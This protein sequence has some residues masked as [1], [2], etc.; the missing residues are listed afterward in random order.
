MNRNSLIEY[1]KL[2]HL[3]I[4]MTE[5]QFYSILKQPALRSLN[6]YHSTV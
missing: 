3:N 6:L 2:C 4:I 1:F 5:S